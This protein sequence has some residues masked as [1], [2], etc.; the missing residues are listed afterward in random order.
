MA[1]H[2]PVRNLAGVPTRD[3][4]VDLVV[5][6]ENTEG[7]TACG[8]VAQRVKDAYNQ[9]LANG[10]KTRDLGGTL[11]TDAFA[12]SVIERLQG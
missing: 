2:Q 12:Q 3:A 4:G 5:V 9:A 11:G 6:R 10:Q 1:S 8:Q 7:D